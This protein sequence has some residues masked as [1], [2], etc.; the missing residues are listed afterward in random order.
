MLRTLLPPPGGSWK[1]ATSDPNG[2][3]PRADAPRGAIEI[4]K[5]IVPFQETKIY[6]I[7][8]YTCN[9]NVIYVIYVIYVLNVLYVLF[10]IY[11]INIICNIC[12][13]CTICSICNKC[14]KCNICNICNTCNICCICNIM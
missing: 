10:V 4:N 1:D 8:N 3:K 2:S 14:N 12:N 11:A 5:E 9:I 13:I 7:L 6:C